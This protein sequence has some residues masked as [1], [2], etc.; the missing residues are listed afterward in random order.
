[1]PFVG[2]A[3]LLLSSVRSSRKNEEADD[4]GCN[5]RVLRRD[6]FRIIATIAMAGCFVARQYCLL[7]L[8]LPLPLVGQSL[9]A[10]AAS[11]A[12]SLPPLWVW[13][14]DTFG[15]DPMRSR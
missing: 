9:V 15:V 1:M 4:I 7:R 3:N 14:K 11:G 5:Y 13:M 2:L 10:F 6:N 12:T 8:K